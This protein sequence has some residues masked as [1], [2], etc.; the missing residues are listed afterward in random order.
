MDICVGKSER[1]KAKKN[2]LII[3]EITSITLSV[4]VV[5]GYIFSL[6]WV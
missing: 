4:L 3:N 2:L 5:Y 6:R 1:K